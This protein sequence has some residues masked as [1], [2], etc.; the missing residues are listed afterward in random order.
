MPKNKVTRGFGF[1]RFKIEWD[2]RK[3]IN[4]LHGLILGGKWIFV[5]MVKHDNMTNGGLS[6]GRNENGREVYQVVLLV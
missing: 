3:V 5:Q 4:L 2:A 6:V 1:V